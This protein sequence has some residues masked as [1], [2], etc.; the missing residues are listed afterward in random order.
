MKKFIMGIILIISIF[1]FS[2]DLINQITHEEYS[3]I[4]S[5]LSNDILNTV[6]G[7]IV[8]N[9]TNEA[10]AL[11]YYE[12]YKNEYSGSTTSIIAEKS[13][14]LLKYS[15]TAFL[16]FAFST[17]DIVKNL[18]SDILYYSLMFPLGMDFYFLT[19]PISISSKNKYIDLILLKNLV[20]KN[21][22]NKKNSI[23]LSKKS[24]MNDYIINIYVHNITQKIITNNSGI[25][26]S[27]KYTISYVLTMEILN[28]NNQKIF[29]KSYSN[30]EIIKD[31]EKLNVLGFFGDLALFGTGL[32]LLF[33][34]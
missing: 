7:N 9:I 1:S 25:S 23:I 31:E 15:P 10:S 6:K 19:N 5:V 29:Q 33:N 20:E 34:K 16:F 32:I 22:I 2:E 21:L 8:I 18:N 28:K 11:R 13:V 24:N 3:K 14:P 30:Y 26:F 27:K 17:F 12:D 4:A